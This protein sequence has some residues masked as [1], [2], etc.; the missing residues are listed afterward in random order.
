MSVILGFRLAVLS[1][2]C[3]LLLA[4]QALAASPLLKIKDLKQRVAADSPTTYTDLLKLVFPEPTPGEKEAPAGPLVRKIDN[5]N[6][7]PSL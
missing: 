6:D 7:E 4:G 1:A 5:E 3:L 2:A